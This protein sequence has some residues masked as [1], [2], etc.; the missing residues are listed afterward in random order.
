MRVILL[1]LITI[2][3]FTVDCYFNKIQQ[4]SISRPGKFLSLTTNDDTTNDLLK[5]KATSDQ[6]KFGVKKLDEVKSS[7]SSQVI[8]PVEKFKTSATFGSLTV[9]DLKKKMIKIDST[10]FK[11][12]PVR[13]EDLNG[14]NPLIPLF[15]STVPFTFAYFGFQLSS[16]LSAH[17]AV[18]FLASDIYTLQRIAIVARNIVV[19]LATLATAFS[20]IIGFGLLALGLTVGVGVLKGELDPTKKDVDIKDLQ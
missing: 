12:L 5:Y 18:G 20:A 2:Q 4:V 19:G 10:E 16:Y 7:T 3:S 17:F 1:L 11:P 13:T 9:A 8:P 6:P 15:S 14:I